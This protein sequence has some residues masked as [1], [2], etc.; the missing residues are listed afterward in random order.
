MSPRPSRGQLRRE[1]EEAGGRKVRR[2]RL[3]RRRDYSSISLLL[4]EIKEG[5]RINWMPQLSRRSGF[6][7]KMWE[8]SL[9]WTVPGFH[10]PPVKA[11]SNRTGV[12]TLFCFT[13]A[14]FISCWVF[15]SHL[16]AHRGKYLRTCQDVLNPAGWVHIK[17]HTNTS[18]WPSYTLSRHYS[19]KIN[20]LWWQ[21]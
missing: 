15:I 19:V 16:S 14:E 5:L 17:T 20:S 18:Q 6:D 13:S 8:T 21:T 10:A 12:F 7:P 3:N 9:Q 11:L 4:S 2:W 1:Q